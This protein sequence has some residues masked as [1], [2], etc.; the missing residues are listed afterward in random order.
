[1]TRQPFSL[2]APSAVSAGRS[3]VQPQPQ[4][5]EVVPSEATY[6]TCMQS[7]LVS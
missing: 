2:D 6:R 7:I 4:L 3:S 5:A 1:M